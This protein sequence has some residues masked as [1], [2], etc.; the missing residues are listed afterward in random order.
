MKATTSIRPPLVE[1]GIPVYQRAAYVGEAI[2]SVL[3][4]S[5]PNWRLI[6]SDDG[7]GGGE[8][9]AAVEPYLADE[10]VHYAPTETRLGEAGNWNRIIRLASARYVAILHDD[11]RWH[12]DF[13]AHRVAFMDDHPDCAF[14]FSGV[15]GIDAAGR[16]LGR[17]S[18]PATTGL[19]DSTRFA[20]LMLR[21]NVVGPPACVLMRRSALDVAGLFDETLAHLDYEM[22]FRLGL[23]FPVGCLPVWDADYRIHEG[24]TTFGRASGPERVL[25]LARRLTEVA[26]RERPGLLTTRSRRKL[27]ANVLLE[28]VSFSARTSATTKKFASSLLLHAVAAY[29][30]ALFD[31]RVLDWVRVAVGP[32]LRVRLAQAR[33]GLVHALGKAS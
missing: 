2:E 4:Q 12:P 22:W 14:V 25:R 31:K 27:R 7:P 16:F 24:S 20:A 28:E 19:Y 5:F 30:P 21:E 15:N 6:V 17:S 3:A 10:R 33:R 13:L 18:L 11:D 29:P 32:R 23:R 8:V 9:A 1:V 26:D